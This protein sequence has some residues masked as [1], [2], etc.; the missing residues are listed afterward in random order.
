MPI[1]TYHQQELTSIASEWNN[2]VLAESSRDTNQ[3]TSSELTNKESTG[4]IVR[5]LCEL[6][7]IVNRIESNLSNDPH[8]F[9]DEQ[10]INI[11]TIASE[12]LRVILD[13][14]EDIDQ[15]F[16]Q[17][18]ESNKN[19]KVLSL[20]RK[21]LFHLKDATDKLIFTATQVEVDRFP[22]LKSP[23]DHDIIF[24]HQNDKLVECYQD[25]WTPE[26]I[27]KAIQMVDSWN[28]GDPEEQLE[29]F[30][31]L[32]RIDEGRPRKLFE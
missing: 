25:E 6:S 26:N 23:S 14:L 1:A 16:L 20:H 9:T 8:S 30:E 15:K 31:V 2:N 12:Q 13:S 19:D 21:T 27:T 18:N 28:Q 29:T 17:A 32:K 24:F 4:E 5:V 10:L 11:S 22:A 7:Y 3:S